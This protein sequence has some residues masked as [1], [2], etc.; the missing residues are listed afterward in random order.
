MVIKLKSRETFQKQEQQ[1]VCACWFM[2]EL[3][4]NYIYVHGVTL[5]RWS[6]KLVN[7]V[8]TTE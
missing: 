8:E 6:L 1:N 4:I 5:S 7:K 2:Q 3:F